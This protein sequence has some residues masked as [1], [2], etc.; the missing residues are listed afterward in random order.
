MHILLVAQQWAP[1]KGVPQRRGQWMVSELVKAGHT[2]DIVAPPPHYPTGTLLSDAPEDQ[3]GAVTEVDGVRLFRSKFH[4]HGQG[5]VSRIRDQWVVST[6]SV[7]TA[8]R[9]A[10]TQVPDVVLA[11]APPLPAVFTALRV[12]KKVKRPYVVDLRDAWPELVSFVAAGDAVDGKASAKARILESA[13]KF[14]AWVFGRMLRKADG[15]ISTSSWHTKA[16]AGR[17]KKPVGFV[18]NLPLVDLDSEPPAPH[19]AP[20]GAPL[21][22]VYCGTLGRAQGLDNAIR[23]VAIARKRGVPVNFRVVGD[24]AHLDR[25]VALDAELSAGVDFVGRV[26][27]DEMVD[28]YAWADTVLVHLQDWEP[29]TTTI[30]SKVF[31]AI[32]TNKHVTVAARGESA[33]IVQRAGAGT[34]VAPMDPVAL[35]TSFIDTASHRERLMCNAH[36]QAWLRS[37]LERDHPAATLLALL[38]EVA[39]V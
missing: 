8:R 31:E 14:P 19:S 37:E 36:G 28:H 29:L 5:L 24:G 38:H 10:E 1:E 20:P 22:V 13:L 7:A 39:D 35:A 11:T 27:R 26:P 12:A 18:S 25:L 6:S 3:E 4:P 16:L 9:A 32:A 33:E 34:V 17:L 2:V 23:A 15:L 21:N 30:P